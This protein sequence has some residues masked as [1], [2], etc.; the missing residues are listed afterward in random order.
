MIETTSNNPFVIQEGRLKDGQLNNVYRHTWVEDGMIFGGRGEVIGRS[1]DFSTISK[2][3]WF[4]GFFFLLLLGR[5]LWLQIL[6]GEYYFKIAEGNRIRQERVE[7]RR[8]IIYDRNMKPLVHNVANFLLYVVPADLPKEPA[9]KEAILK[10]LA[11]TIAPLSPR[12]GLLDMDSSRNA[13]DK[14]EIFRQID[15]AIRKINPKSLDAFQPLFITDNIDYDKAMLLELESADWKGVK[16]STN[17]RRNY[18]LEAESLSHLLGYTGKISQAEYKSS[19]AEYLPIDYIG[20][21]GLEYFYENELR[22]ING[23]KQIEVDALGKTKKVLNSNE[24]Q[25]G[26]NLVL[27]IDSQ[28]QKKL[29]EILTNQLKTLNL[30]KASAVVT[31]PRNGEIIA[32]VSLPAYN[33]NLFARGITK[34]EYKKLIDDPNRPLFNRSVAGEF[35]CGSVIKPVMAAA[36]LN[37]GVVS[38]ST[39]FLSNGGLKIGSWV[40]PDWKAGGHG[41]TNVKKAIAESVNTYFYIIGG[42]YEDFQGLGLDRIV[43]YDKLFG[44]G[45]QTGIDLPGEANGFV[46]TLDWKEN[47]KKE[48]WY[49]GDTYHLAIGQG[50]LTTT[51]LQIAQFTAYFAN[52]G[53]MYR[54]HLVREITEAGGQ[55]FHDVEVSITKE[56]LVKQDAVQVVREGMRQT[57][58]AGSARSINAVVPVAVAGKTGTA[59]WSSKK[60]PQAWFT[61]FAPYDNPNLAITVLV[62]EGKEGSTAA[63]PVA[64][65]FL[66]WYYSPKT[67]T[68]T[69]TSTSIK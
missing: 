65:E 22:G 47:V 13:L 59:Q 10:K 16:L 68:T 40:F 15:E 25:D 30:K 38:E 52:G 34:D 24:A 66:K 36:A 1:F 8:G 42:G 31:D 57:V 64:R 56:N 67:A 60:D 53:K 62:E 50:D 21:N 55:K 32:L 19:S 7:A 11:G 51:P 17:I 61:A 35:P 9:E 14:E 44:L 33:D 48:H 43:R 20:K 54:P 46:P 4:F 37:E 6:T 29:E 69:A 26:H 3:S 18:N 45:E 39:Q 28:A 58:T 49:T 63:V 27:T 12:Q 2:V 41:M 23:H 5:L